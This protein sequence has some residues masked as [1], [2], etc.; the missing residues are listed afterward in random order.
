[1]PRFDRI[2]ADETPAA[3]TGAP[4]S[5]DERFIALLV[6]ETPLDRVESQELRQLVLH[7]LQ[8]LTPEELKVVEGRFQHKKSPG[9]VAR[10]LQLSRDD[11]QR[12]ERQALDK[13]RAPLVE[14]MEP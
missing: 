14:Y 9:A 2:A 12:L 13:L 10:H 7:A 11:V 6:P 5:L 1:M 3:S 8:A 4:I